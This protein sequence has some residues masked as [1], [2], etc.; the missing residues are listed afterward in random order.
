M[1][2]LVRRLKA[3]EA[4][5]AANALDG[6][7][8]DAAVPERQWTEAVRPELDQLAR[9]QYC[10][11]FR[12]VRNLVTEAKRAMP[13]PVYRVLDV[14]AS[15]GYYHDVLAAFDLPHQYTALDISPAMQAFARNKY[16]G[17][18]FDVCDA[19]QMTYA[20]ESFDL[21]I[22][23]CSLIHVLDW[24]KVVAECARVS[25]RLVIFHRTPLVPSTTDE[26]WEQDAYGVR[27]LRIHL[28][29]GR[30]EAACSRAGLKRLATEIVAPEIEGGAS[31][32]SSL[33]TK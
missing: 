16:P 8:K 33:W 13:L 4:E 32:E 29:R 11:P 27:M 10:A 20:S 31:M 1:I 25:R 30:F 24:E 26:H 5:R 9:G 6:G 28:S 21:V 14:G 22:E 18:V 23:G 19:R 17:I 12:A 2:M 15:T 3:K 7:W